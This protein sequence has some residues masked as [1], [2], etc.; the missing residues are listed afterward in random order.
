M[1]KREGKN[2]KYH[3]IV[4]LSGGT[5]STYSLYLT[6]K[7]GLN[8]LVVHFPSNQCHQLIQRVKISCEKGQLSAQMVPCNIFAGFAFCRSPIVLS[9]KSLLT[10]KNPR[11]VS[12]S[13]EHTERRMQDGL[14]CRQQTDDGCR[15]GVSHIFL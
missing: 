8:P 2:K 15:V 5:D 13:V 9:A 10:E 4:S 14:W 7:Y 1:L 11:I 6:K 3:C 12:E